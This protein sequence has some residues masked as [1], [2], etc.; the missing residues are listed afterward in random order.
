MALLRDRIHAHWKIKSSQLQEIQQLENF[1]MSSISSSDQQQV[2][3]AVESSFRNIFNKQ[4]GIHIHKFSMLKSCR[5]KVGSD[6]ASGSKKFVL[7]LSEYALTDHEESDLRKGLNFSIVNPH[8]NLDMACAVESVITKLPQILGMEFR[9]KVR[10]ML[11][12]SKSPTSNIRKKELK[13]VKSLRL[14]K[15]IRILPADKGN[16]TVVLN[17]IKYRDKINTLLKSGVYEPLA[18]DPTARVERRVQQILAKYKTALPAKVK[19][20]LTP[21]HSKPPHPKI[22]KPDIPLRPTA[23]SIG[24]PCYALA[25]FLQEILSP[26]AS[27]S[28]IFVKNSGHFIELLMSVNL[29]RQDM[30]ASFNVVS[31][32][33]RTSRRSPSGHQ[34]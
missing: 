28:G 17:E 24:S 31:L 15:G 27:R 22:H 7:N 10:S 30:L 29:R 14:N 20:K 8:F 1:L 9:W 13:A 6:P 26:L 3:T 2:F 21:Y 25:G 18:K 32:H 19:Q 11:Q 34:K 5:D 16:C 4:K 33:Q 23:S 12:K